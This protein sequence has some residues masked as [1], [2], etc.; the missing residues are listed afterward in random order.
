LGG[1]RNKE[2]ISINPEQDLQLTLTSNFK[3]N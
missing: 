3:I 2:L 1:N